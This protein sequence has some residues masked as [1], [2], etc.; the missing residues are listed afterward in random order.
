MLNVMLRERKNETRGF[1]AGYGSRLGWT[2]FQRTASR[3]SGDAGAGGRPPRGPS[4]TDGQLSPESP[5][6]SPPGNR[7]AARPALSSCLSQVASGDSRFASSLGICLVAKFIF[8]LFCLYTGKVNPGHFLKCSHLFIF[9][10]CKELGGKK[11][12][13][14]TQ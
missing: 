12:S 11:V 4:P 13:L 7:T 2:G 1:V 9:I 5:P 3:Q 14:N 8:V 6:V 10:T